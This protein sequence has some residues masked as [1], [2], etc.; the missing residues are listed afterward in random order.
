[1]SRYMIQHYT[2]SSCRALRPGSCIP[3]STSCR[4]RFAG[5]PGRL[6]GAGLDI[7]QRRLVG[8]LAV[9]ADFERLRP[10]LANLSVKFGHKLSGITRTGNGWR[11][12]L[13]ANGASEDR[14]YA[15]VILAMGSWDELP[16]GAAKPEDYWR[17]GSVGTPAT[18][19][20][21]GV[22]YIVSGNGDG[23]L[24]EIL[25]LLIEQF[26]HVTFTRRFLS[27][28]G[29][30]DLRTAAEQVFE[31]ASPNHD[32]E[33]DLQAKLL[34][35]LTLHGVIDELRGSLRKDRAITL[36]SNGPLLAADRAAQLN[37]CM[38]FAVLQ[39]A[40]VEG[41][42]VKR[43]SGF[44]TGVVGTV[45]AMQLS[46]IAASGKPVND[47]Y[48]HVI[49]RHGPDLARR[50]EPAQDLLKAY[51]AYILPFL[52]SNPAVAAPPVLPVDCFEVLSQRLRIEKTADHASKPHQL[53]AAERNSHMIEVVEDVATHVIVEKGGAGTFLS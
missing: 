23:A 3:T 27:F 18:E 29:G 12:S 33:K 22:T 38:V 10:S 6:A 37:Q 13:E 48:K 7:K 42:V 17:P 4:A 43:T 14:L 47:V 21:A 34:P 35:M 36:N 2:F 1:M 15:H 20:E 31:C 45:G 30:D 41:L 40:E 11:L 53:N 26:E 8:G 39:A 16:C 52:A 51:K 44:V 19:P 25:A 9:R 49:V 24:T 32:M 50:Y 46:G 5:R 28:F